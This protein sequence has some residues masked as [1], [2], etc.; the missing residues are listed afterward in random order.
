MSS[1]ELRLPNSWAH[2]LEL[3]GEV[4]EGGVAAQVTCCT[5]TFK[6][7]LKNIMSLQVLGMVWY[8]EY[9]TSPPA[10]ILNGFLYGRPP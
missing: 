6:M 5:V 4:T 3:S 10:H 1:E 7:I 2:L 9:P 8:Q